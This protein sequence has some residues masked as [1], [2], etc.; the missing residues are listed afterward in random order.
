MAPMTKPTDEQITALSTALE[1]FTRRYK[2]AD[3]GGKTLNLLDTQTLLYV[4]EHPACGPTDVARYLGVA[5]TTISSVTDRL[6]KHGFLERRRIESNRRSVALTL[7]P[8]G[9]AHVAAYARAHDDLYRMM[10]DR[11][12]PAERGTLIELI[13]KIAYHDD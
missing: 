5:A 8:K 13:T 2:L 3:V 6:V 4:S 12:S 11:L 9:E 7:S 10:L 1:T